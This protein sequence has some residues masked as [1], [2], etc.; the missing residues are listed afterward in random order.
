MMSRLML[1]L[2]STASTGIFSTLPISDAS[3]AVALTSG[4]PDPRFIYDTEFERGGKIPIGTV[5]AS[6]EYIFREAGI[7]EVEMERRTGSG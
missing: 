3:N 6:A 7:E 4:T 5:H 1:N 2:H